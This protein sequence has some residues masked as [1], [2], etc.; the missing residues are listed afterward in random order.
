MITLNGLRFR[1]VG[2]RRLLLM[3]P[4]DILSPVFSVFMTD[5]ENL[6]VSLGFS[7]LPTC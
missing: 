6:C 5:Q 2:Y 1:L 3:M 7:L 4:F